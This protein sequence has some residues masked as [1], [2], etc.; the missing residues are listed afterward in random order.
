MSDRKFRIRL[1]EQEDLEIV[2]ALFLEYAQSLNF[3]LCFQGF[4]QELADLPGRYTPPRGGL[5]LG[6]LG[7]DPVAVVGLRPLVEEADACEMKRLYVRPEARGKGLGQELAL[8]S[9]A[10]ARDAGFQTLR[11]DTMESMASARK[12]YAGLGFKETAPYYDNPLPGVTYM[13]L[14]LDPS[15]TD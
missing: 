11:L 14:A 7:D 10:A 4:D 9:I 13:A 8:V 12:M 15:K 6:C 5:W 1:A 3:S 2:R